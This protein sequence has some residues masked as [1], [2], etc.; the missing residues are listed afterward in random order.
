MRGG[1]DDAGEVQHHDQ[2]HR[3]GDQ[4]DH[5]LA[6]PAGRR[7]GHASGGGSGQTLTFK[8]STISGNTAT[9]GL[10]GFLYAYSNAGI[11]TISQC[12]LTQNASLASGSSFN[13]G[14]GALAFYSSSGTV[15]I[16]NST[17]AD[18]AANSPGEIRN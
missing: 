14:G 10:G 5:H 7:R 18:N 1:P 16:S 3:R 2:D 11:I 17:I 4:P 8:N 6:G 12:T 9:N 15:N 13:P